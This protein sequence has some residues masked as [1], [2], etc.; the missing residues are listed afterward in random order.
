MNKYTAILSQICC[1]AALLV[2]SACGGG[3]G[4]D[5]PSSTK[6]ADTSETA[7]TTLSGKV[8]DGY[9]RGARVFLDRNGNRIY[10]NGE[11]TALSSAGGNFSLDVN[12]DEGD[13]YPVVA[14]VVA[15]QTVDED[16]GLTVTE[17]YLL[18]APKGRWAFISPLTKMVKTVQ[19]QNP[20]Y[21]ELQ[22]VL[23]VRSELGIDDNV[24][25]FEDYIAKGTGGN[26]VTDPQLA[27]EYS[28]THKAAR[29]VAA[30]LGDLQADIKQNLGGQ[31]ADDEQAAV[32]YMISDKVLEQAPVVKQALDGERNN[33][34]V[35]DVD[36]LIGTTSG[37]ID[38]TE[39]DADLLILYDQRISQDLPFW[40]MTPPEPVSL[41]P[42]ADDTASVDVTV[43][44]IFD[45]ALDETLIS[46]SLV[47]LSGPNGELSG[48]VSY[49]AAEK[50][51]T[52]VPDQV[53]LPFSNYQVTVK[54]ELSDSLGNNLGQD[55]VWSFTTIFDQS[56]PPLPDF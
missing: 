5:A 35:A 12:P 8:A 43:G 19:E 30:L 42:P 9:L 48:T 40:D 13:L 38:S 46:D 53:L 4:G 7:V 54:T 37:A 17:D 26:E 44:V 45:E 2:L 32:A 3:G 1:A 31:I 56:P 28:R 22:A 24:S 10:D 39:L 34:Q 55:I 50:K 49:N 16:S 23:K 47:S 27:K 29:V 18:E 6:T 33:V 41:I 52:F 20:S 15:G 51:L 25:L 21:T 11:P 36:T 14:Q